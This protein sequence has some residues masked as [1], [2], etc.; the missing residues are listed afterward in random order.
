[1]TYAARRA[2]RHIGRLALIVLIV[3]LAV[4]GIGGMDAV[5]ERM[6][7]TGANRMLNEAE[8]QARTALVSAD[9]VADIDAQD[10][11]MRADIDA[12]FAGTQTTV[13]RVSTIDLPLAKKPKGQPTYGLSAVRLLEDPRITELAELTA[14]SWPQ[15]PGQ[16]A[17]PDAALQRVHLGIGDEIPLADGTT[18][19]ILG[20]WTA[21]DPADPAWHGD[22]A[23]ASGEDDGT[24]GPAVVTT[25]ALADRSDDATVIWEILP[26]DLRLS[27]IPLLQRA[28]STLQGLPQ[29]IDPHNLHSTRVQSRLD[30]TLQRQTA[31]VTATRGL[32]VAPLLILALLGALV[33]GVVLTTLSGARAEEVALLRARGTSVRRL[34]LTAMAETALLAVVGA[35]LALLLLA[36]LVGVSGLALVT[37]AGAATFSVVVAGV[38]TLRNTGGADAVRPD[39]QRK[40]ASRALPVLLVPAGIAVA[41]AALSG[42]QL[43]S[44]GSVLRADG[45]P[46]P[47][48]SVAPSLLLIAAC[49]LAP[50]LAAPIAALAELLLRRTRGIAPILPLRQISRRM[51][52]TAVAIVCLA[53]AAA[54]VALAVTAPASADAAEQRTRDAAL[55]A[56]VRM[57][58]DGG[59]DVTAEVAATWD[60][61]TRASEVLRAPLTV[62][63]ERAVFVAGVP[64]VSGRAH[65]ARAVSADSIPATITRSLS[66]RLG[67]KVG[68]VFTAQI[69]YVTHPVSIQ[70]SKV[71][72]TLPGVGDGWAVA[73]GA[74]E[75]SIVEVQLTANELWLDSRDPA[76][77]ARQLRAQATHPVRILT[78]AQVSAAPVTSV[79]P[80]VLTAGAL[81]AAVL[82]AIGF[83]AASTT[84]AGAR[85]DEARV[86]Q[87]LGLHRSRE[88]ALRTGE[89]VAVGVYAVLAG[90]VLGAAVALSVLPIVLGGGA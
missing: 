38:S 82:G 51:S 73:A 60:G 89:A 31:A 41:V 81:L 26:V 34:T 83:L 10:A 55:G 6:L 67:A 8:P 28:L 49:A 32:L 3:A 88:R 19:T 90:A 13:S 29:Q 52:G 15:Q 77:T 61:V 58:S 57:I 76:A 9:A 63:A 56:D 11:E 71:V 37:A 64:G 48:A 17:L 12:A 79:A 86:L 2:G 68:T 54:A 35:G 33:L 46:D 30:D 75:L 40:D 85:R 65:V 72:D 78:A 36:I 69:R 22:P 39:A 5:A 24:V 87:S 27:D 23:A 7:A 43:F 20:T 14:G 74:G 84:A 42:W 59:L 18:L 16:V 21:K 45:S 25:G 50:L 66:E 80:A 44:N 53:L 70:V 62:G 1:M 4:A 47:L